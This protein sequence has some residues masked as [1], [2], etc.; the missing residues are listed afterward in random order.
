MPAERSGSAP[1]HPTNRMNGWSRK[2]PSVKP[3]SSLEDL[4]SRRI[5]II[6]GAMG[7]M[8]Q[9]ENLTE[10]DF[11]GRRFKDAKKLL[12]GNND[13]LTLTRPDVVRKVHRAYLDAGMQIPGVDCGGVYVADPGS[14]GFALR[15]HRGVVALVFPAER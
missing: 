10:E 7:T 8:L 2:L 14:G 1:V 12:K 9:R 11:R 15:V 5:A 13:L 6:D 3:T 4:C